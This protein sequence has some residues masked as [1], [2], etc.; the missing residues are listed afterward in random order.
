MDSWTPMPPLS[1]F[2]GK[3][4]HTAVIL[5]DITL[6]MSTKK[7]KV[8]GLSQ[9][10]RLDRLIGHMRSH[11]PGDLD[12]FVCQQQMIAVPTCVRRLMSHWVLFPNRIDRGTMHTIARS[13]I[14]HKKTLEALFEMCENPYDSLVIESERLPHRSR[15]RINGYMQVPGIN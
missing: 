8:D 3:R 15:V 9:R 12:I 7:S 6:E 10:Q 14:I 13:I 1:F 11:H 2:N 5:D 4:G